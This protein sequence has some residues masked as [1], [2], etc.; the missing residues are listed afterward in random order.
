MSNLS[1]TLI[2][3][4]LTAL[5]AVAGAGLLPSLPI[6]AIVE[7]SGGDTD[8]AQFIIRALLKL[9]ENDSIRVDQ[10]EE[11]SVKEIL[12]LAEVEAEKAVAGTDRLKNLPDG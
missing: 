3:T 6:A 12:D 4:A 8:R 9:V 10:I 11:L 7:A 5:D 1:K 2:T